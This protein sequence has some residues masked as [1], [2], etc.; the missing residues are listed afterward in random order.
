[1]KQGEK[2]LEVQEN[3]IKYLETFGILPFSVI[4][5]YGLNDGGCLSITFWIKE[6][7]DEFL[8]LVEYKNLCDKSGYIIVEENNTIM[9]S[10]FALIDLYSK[11][12]KHE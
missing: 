1:M 5:T 11:I 9:I 7:I 2:E 3:M 12:M 8:K 4:F 10:G 6:E